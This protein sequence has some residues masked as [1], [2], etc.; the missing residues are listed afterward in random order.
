MKE[1]QTVSYPIGSS[2]T[3]RQTLH[4]I[5]RFI[6]AHKVPTKC[7]LQKRGSQYN[8]YV[9]RNV[10]EPSKSAYAWECELDTEN[11]V[12]QVKEKTVSV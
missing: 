2:V 7:K 9:V 10:A 6:P 8:L 1:A 11:K 5:E 4:I 12:E 3:F